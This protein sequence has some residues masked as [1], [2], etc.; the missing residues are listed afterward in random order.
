[1]LMPCFYIRGGSF[2]VVFK[3]EDG[4]ACAELVGQ[5]KLID[6]IKSSKYL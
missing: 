5:Q 1:M 3:I 4:K 2:F 6:E